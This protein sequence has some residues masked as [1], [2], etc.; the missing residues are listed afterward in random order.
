MVGRHAGPD[1]AVRRR[2]AID[3][4]DMKVGIGAQ[5]PVGGIKARRAG[6]HD[7]NAVS[8]GGSLSI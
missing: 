1:Q 3:D 6:T 5:Q 7:G 2:Q 8:H 4:V